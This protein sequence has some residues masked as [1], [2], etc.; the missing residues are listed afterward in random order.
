VVSKPLSQFNFRF[1][2]FLKYCFQKICRI[3]CNK[4]L[5]NARYTLLR[6]CIFV[7]VL[8]MVIKIFYEC[9]T[10]GNYYICVGYVLKVTISKL[11]PF[12]SQFSNISYVAVKL[13]HVNSKIVIA[14]SAHN[15]HNIVV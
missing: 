4:L 13:K 15:Q 2:F 12:S 10:V 6:I 9:Y 8:N 1:N 3:V 7:C 5:C 11:T 14:P